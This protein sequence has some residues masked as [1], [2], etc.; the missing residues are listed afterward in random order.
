LG[1]LALV[2]SQLYSFPGAKAELWEPLFFIV[3]A[4]LAGGK[5][6]TLSKQLLNEEVGSM[7]LGFA[8]T[9][10]ALLRF[11]PQMAV[12]LGA[13]SC[14]SSCLFPQRMPWHQIV[15]NV[16]LGA[17]EAL[18]GST[19]YLSLNRW[20]PGLR[21][22]ESFPAV[23][24][25]ALTFY[26]VNTFGVA[27]IIGLCTGERVRKV[28]KENFLWTAPSYFATASVGALALLVFRS[29]MSGMLLFVAPVIFLVY[30]SY[31]VY[32]SRAEDKIRHVQEIQLS[33]EHLAE[34]YLATIKSLALAIDAKDQYTHQHILRVQR[35]AVAIANEMKLTG[36][37][38]EAV[39]TGA[40]LHDI[41]KLGVPEYVLL[42]P[43]RLTSEE[44]DKIKKHPEIG[45]AILDPVEFPWPVLPVVRHHHEK[46]DGTGYPDGLKGE[47]IPLTARIMAVA[48]VYDALTSSRSYRRAWT[49]E[50]AASTIAKDAGSH[51]DPIVV[52]AFLR[53]IDGVVR[54]M[55]EVGEGP[56]V[57][58]MA[59]GIEAESK[60]EIA[61]N[62]ISR[63]SAELWAI[64][65]VAQ[66]L[67]SSIGTYE[68]IQIL[69][70]KLEAIFPGVCCALL[71]V[72]EC[73]DL[74]A[75]AAN[76]LNAEFF[77]GAHTMG[78]R[79]LSRRVLSSGK[80][81]MGEY[82]PDDLM[83]SGNELNQW[84]ELRS[85][86]VM[87]L[88][89][90]GRPLG[91]INLYDPEVQAFN[92]F[93]LDV[94]GMIAE[95]VAPA[96]HNGLLF[97]RNHAASDLDPL[98]GLFT[99]RYLNERVGAEI[100]AGSQ[101]SLIGI[102]LESFRSIN[103]GFGHDK[104]DSVLCEV[105][106]LLREAAG[107]AAALSRYGG[108]EFMLLVSSKTKAETRALAEG[109]CAL[110]ESYDPG[111]TRHGVG[112]LGLTASS[113]IATYPDDG[114]EATALISHADAEM[115]RH[116]M[117]RKLGRMAKARKDRKAA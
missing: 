52:E 99:M 75:K 96:I 73:G 84:T 29:N 66:S 78:E 33:Q 104:G 23:I 56:L 47:D 64:Y 2:A 21:S 67:A 81:F 83:L 109:L 114:A 63:T 101:F 95:R 88:I 65:E 10:T 22:F 7:S 61:A 71:L 17:F 35:Y 20:S 37:E 50:K 68:M 3:L 77:R 49:H 44:F 62:H 110:I 1:G 26:A 24:A 25:S 100:G 69:S 115:R 91:T 87:P 106:A 11:G 92:A 105:A 70:H 30:Q 59:P 51:F 48:D 8:I 112:D 9:F 12:L 31:V 74:R 54:E 14:L 39:N 90:E 93:D 13:A 111:L 19:V 82:D 32:I 16:S 85:S 94:L 116:K 6:V 34:L 42:K 43:G 107:P 45:A 41:G 40:L 53:V 55:A 113:G 36:A 15:F 5:K 60:T 86:I 80:A 108:D 89:S 58:A 28:W 46:W 97:D 57:A 76:G 72:E 117:E 27:I 38:L 102:D 4:V 18:I 98:T 103:E 79:S